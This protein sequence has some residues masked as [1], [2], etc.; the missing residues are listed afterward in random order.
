MNIIEAFQTGGCVVRRKA[1]WHNVSVNLI[2]ILNHRYDLSK[3]D[4]LADDWE[5]FGGATINRVDLT[6]AWRKALADSLLDKNFDWSDQDISK[7]M[8]YKEQVFQ[9]LLKNLDI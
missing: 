5:T 1:W 2:E 7:L 4:I 6:R 9:R 8:N 3:E